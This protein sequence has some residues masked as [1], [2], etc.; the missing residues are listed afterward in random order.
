MA[1]ILFYLFSGV[2]IASAVGVVFARTT[3]YNVLFLIMAFFN[4]AGLFLLAG[5]EFLAMILVIV[6]VGAVA[7]LFL[8]VVMMVDTTNIK[9]N[10]TLSRGRWIM[11]LAA[12]IFACELI[13]VAY[14]WSH[15]PQTSDLVAYASP[16]YL[17][18]TH[19]LG[20]LIYT[21]YFYTF[22]I[23]GLI[24]LV[25]MIGA[26]V[27][28]LHGESPRPLRK[29]NITNQLKRRKQDTLTVKHVNFHQGLE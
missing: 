2:L 3:L 1:G 19:A 26:I 12:L 11:M 6:Y 14:Q 16:K 27:L 24:L 8:F 17:T 20:G 25:S 22:Q 5:S 29:Q 15:A 28:T 9:T 18:N 21:H 7:V 10:Q 4:A 13:V 23:A